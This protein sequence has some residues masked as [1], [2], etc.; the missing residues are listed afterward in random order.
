MQKLENYTFYKGRG[1]RM[2]RNNSQ[3]TQK[4]LIGN[5]EIFHV[6]QAGGYAL[7]L[8]GVLQ[9][10]S[11]AHGMSE[12]VVAEWWVLANYLIFLILFFFF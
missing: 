4:T 1:S 2:C 8:S 9:Y 3:C 12:V 10:G 11:T 6:V 7:I 5:V